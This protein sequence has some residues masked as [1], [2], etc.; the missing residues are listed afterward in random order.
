MRITL[1]L[2]PL[3]LSLC[4]IPVC[5]TIAQAGIN[6]NLIAAA[7][8]GNAK[9]TKRLLTAGADANAK[10][11]RGVSPL[12]WATAMLLRH[13]TLTSSS[14]G[15]L[16]QRK[17]M[18]SAALQQEREMLRRAT[19]E[20]REVAMLLID[21]GADVNIDVGTETPLRGAVLVGAK[22]LAEVMIKKGANV[23][24]S[25]NA[26]EAPLHSAIGELHADVAEL[27]INNGANVKAANMSGRTP[28]HFVAIFID[29]PNLAELLIAHGADVNAK[30]K[31]GQTPLGF[32]AKTGN[33]LVAEVLRQ[34]KGT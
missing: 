3:L 21:H 31:N 27:L 4:L 5:D 32:A 7:Q 11:S 9:E 14:S 10:D 29:D 13:Y 23:N 28:L 16:L 34:R 6:T 22:D 26:N 12:L 18:G 19:G 20:W 2:V 25:P 17:A 33:N 15:A 24:G 8:T 30:D 1:L